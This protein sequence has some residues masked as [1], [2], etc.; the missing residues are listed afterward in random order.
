MLFVSRNQG[1]VIIAQVYVDNI[2]FG[3][4]KDDLAQ[5][6]AATIQSEFEM[7]LVGKFKFS[8]DFTLNR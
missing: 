7:N 8:L 6:F 4:I 3:S 2:V 1:E 5:K